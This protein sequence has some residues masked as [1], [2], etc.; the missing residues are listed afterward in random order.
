MALYQYYNADILDILKESYK[1]AEAYIDDAIL[2]ATTKTF[3]KAHE[4]LADMIQRVEGMV[5][6]SKSHN[7]SIEYSK[8]VLIDFAHH[9][10]KKPHPQLRLPD[11]TIKPSQNIR[12]LGIILDQNLNWAPQLAQV[13]GKGSKWSAQIRRLT[14]PSWG[15]TL[16]GAKKLYTGVALP[17]ILYG[18]DTWCTLLHGRHARG[19]R[20]GSVKAIK[21]LTS[22]QRSGALAITEGLQTTPTHT[23]DAHAALLPMVS[24]V[25]K[26]ALMQSHTW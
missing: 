14:R 17:C 21:K 25:K 1:S 7:S 5:E 19:S 24:R 18:I 3:D 23:L 16:K 9:G 10:V 11:I 13:V 15:L 6:W 26:H 4:I 8:L 20:K 12:Y 22:V 2:T